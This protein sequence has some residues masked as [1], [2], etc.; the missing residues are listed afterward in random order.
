LPK[1][2]YKKLTSGKYDEQFHEAAWGSA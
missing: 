2:I 1:R